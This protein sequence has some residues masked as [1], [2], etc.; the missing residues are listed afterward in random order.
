MQN[1]GSTNVNG[2][3]SEAYAITPRSH[4]A[5]RVVAQR[6][7]GR[8]HLNCDGVVEFDDINP[9]ILVLSGCAV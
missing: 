7:T 1:I 6:G 5:R 3:A 2:P 9:F 8:V 4:G